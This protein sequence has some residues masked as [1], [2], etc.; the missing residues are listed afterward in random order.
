MTYLLPFVQDFDVSNHVC[1]FLD[2]V[3]YPGL[4]AAVCVRSFLPPRNDGT[5]RAYGGDKLD[6]SNIVESRDSPTLLEQD[7]VP[8]P[9]YFHMRRVHAR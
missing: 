4:L 2:L 1:A 5:A 3:F 8:A 6:L 9:S 7:G